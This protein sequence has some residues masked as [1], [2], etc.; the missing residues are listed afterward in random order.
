MILSIL[1]YHP[2]VAQILFVD[3]WEMYPCVLV[4]RTIL[5]NRRVV[6]QNVPVTHSAPVFIPALTKDVAILALVHVVYLLFVLWLIIDQCVDVMK[7]IP[8][9]RFRAAVRILF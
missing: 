6:D 3:N 4:L 8:A 2:H 1:V 9:I 5:D 7:D